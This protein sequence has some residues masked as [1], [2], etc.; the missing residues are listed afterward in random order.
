VAEII[1]LRNARKRAQRLRAE[2][3]ARRNRVAFGL[4]KT[5]RRLIE[6]ERDK[7]KRHLNA[8][9]IVPPDE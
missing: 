1:N 7:A 3:E 8:L 4:P 6:A 2:A 9:R 5:E